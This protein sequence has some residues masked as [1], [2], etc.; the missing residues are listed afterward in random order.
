MTAVAAISARFGTGRLSTGILSTRRLSTSRQCRLA[1][2][3]GALLIASDARAADDPARIPPAAAPATI[4]I[5]ALTPV[6]VEILADLGSNT[7]HS[8]DNFPL[9]L[10]KPVTIDGKVVIPAGATGEGEVLNARHNG[11]GGAS[12]ML[13]LAARR[14][15]VDG[16]SL[17]LRS[18]KFGTA[19]EDKT[20][21]VVATSFIPVVGLVTLFTTGGEVKAPSGTRARAK[22]AED[23]TLPAPPETA[24]AP[25]QA[26]S[27]PAPAAAGANPSER[28]PS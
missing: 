20:E 28:Q 6:E 9:R 16:R 12:G 11:I 7:S 27:S 5:P 8:G 3:A 15:T 25:A 21:M 1:L 24:P 23:F 2:A 13:M 18:T 26:P 4:T 22:T 17:R 14:I 19:G 10:A